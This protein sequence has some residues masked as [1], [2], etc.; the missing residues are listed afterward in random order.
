[1]HGYIVM[2]TVEQLTSMSDTIP[3]SSESGCW[4]LVEGVPLNLVP[5]T[6]HIEV[7]FIKIKVGQMPKQ[8]SLH[9]FIQLYNIWKN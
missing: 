7:L 1:M 8:P 5:E 3:E 6:S 9:G 4:K 2:W